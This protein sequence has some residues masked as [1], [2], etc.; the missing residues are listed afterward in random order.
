M[1][2]CLFFALQFLQQNGEG[3]TNDELAKLKEEH[4]KLKVMHSAKCFVY[5]EFKSDLFCLQITF[6]LSKLFPYTLWQLRVCTIRKLSKFHYNFFRIMQKTIRIDVIEFTL[7]FP[8][9]QQN[10]SN[11]LYKI[12]MIYHVL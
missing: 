6:I 10:M 7:Y 5:V 9:W 1:Y 2:D 12:T 8:K 3:N 11:K 4:A